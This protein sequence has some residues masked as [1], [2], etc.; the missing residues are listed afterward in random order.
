MKTIMADEMFSIFYNSRGQ[1]AK[2][3]KLFEL[4]PVM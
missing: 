2:S 1:A 4:N 3:M